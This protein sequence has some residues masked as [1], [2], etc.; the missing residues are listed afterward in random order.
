MKL[1]LRGWPPLVAGVLL[2]MSWYGLLRFCG[3][4]SYVLPSPGQILHA[5]WDERHTLIAAAGLTGLGAL[6]GFLAAI[7]VGFI[8]SALLAL[9]QT[10]QRAVYPYVLILHMTPVIIL[11]PIF[12]LWLGQGLPSI[13]VITFM[14]CFFPVV[15]NTTMGFVSTDRNLQDLFRLCNATK[16]QE[17]RSLRLPAAMPYFLTGA[18][19]AG[20]LAPIGAITGD[21]LAGS[22]ENGEGGLGFMAIAYF[23]QLKIPEL[24]AT[25]AVACILGF[26]FVGAVNLLHWSI[27]HNWHE[28]VRARD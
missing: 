20:T 23:S 19:I 27:L 21:F 9:S 8:G 1:F 4:E 14:I 6:L 2:L 18:K 16:T 3:L 5:G 13:V 17:M 25:G 22:A 28:S 26:V 7:A 10:V 15:A 12:V 24:F 11:A